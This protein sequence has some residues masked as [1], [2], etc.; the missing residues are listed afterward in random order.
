M[1][2]VNVVTSESK[3]RGACK[4]T[5]RHVLRTKLTEWIDSIKDESVAN[6]VKRDAY[7]TGGAIVSLL[8]GEQINDYDVYF[9]TQETALAVAN[10]YAE[11]YLDDK[12]SLVCVETYKFT[13]I[14]GEEEERIRLLF[15]KVPFIKL[16][17]HE[18]FDP[19]FITPTAIS[20]KDIQIVIRFYGEPEQVHR[21]YDFVHCTNYYQYATDKLV[22][23][24][25]A[26]YSILSKTLIYQGSLYP[27][28][29]ILRTRKFIARGWTITAPQ[30]IKM[31]L[32][33]KDVDFKNREVLFDQLISVDAMYIADFF[34]RINDGDD[35]DTSQL[36]DLMEESFDMLINTQED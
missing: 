24:E 8:A 22:L 2:N 21:T 5:I 7:V 33:A 12:K 13:G 6:L 4:K 15:D 35:I 26:L 20:L 27:I 30:M 14:T 25:D 19:R 1:K 31:I 17:N 16:N 29:S 10:Y 34:A 36:A 9:S 28:C 18:E 11:T 23:N 32:Q 3:N